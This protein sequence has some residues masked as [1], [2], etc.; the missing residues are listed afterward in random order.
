[1]TNIFSDA[2][3]YYKLKKELNT[4]NNDI[5]QTAGREIISNFLFLHRA[6]EFSIHKKKD[7]DDAMS[8][9]I[10]DKSKVEDELQAII[11]RLRHPFSNKTIDNTIDADNAEL[12]YTI[13]DADT[14]ENEL[15]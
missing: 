10:K 13:K 3:N 15:N 6:D 8:K 1:M 11:D 12:D 2:I 14:S 7:T 9:L 5:N 4:I